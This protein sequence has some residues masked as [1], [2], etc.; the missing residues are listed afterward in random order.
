[1]EENEKITM[2]CP[3]CKKSFQYGF[4][5]KEREIIFKL[6]TGDGTFMRK[7]GEKAAQ[8]YLNKNYPNK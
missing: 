1:M 2:N 3:H 7:L 6:L 5:D 4:T 8:A